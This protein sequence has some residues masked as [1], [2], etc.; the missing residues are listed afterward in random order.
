MRDID[1]ALIGLL[2]SCRKAYESIP[3]RFRHQAPIGVLV[4][5]VAR[6]VPGLTAVDGQRRGFES[7]YMHA[8][9][10]VKGQN[11]IIDL[12]PTHVYPGPI[13][14]KMTPESASHDR[15]LASFYLDVNALT[16]ECN[17]NY[18]NEVAEILEVTEGARIFLSLP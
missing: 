10:K 7:A 15:A 12:L 14:V 6:L 18:A 17:K 11:N 4:R 13:V 9:L 3:V 5:V 16:D 8:W 2:D 1:P